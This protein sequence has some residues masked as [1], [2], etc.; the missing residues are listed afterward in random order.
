M[1]HQA[2]FFVISCITLSLVF[3][4]CDVEESFLI[5]ENYSNVTIVS[6]FISHAEDSSWGSDQLPLN[7]LR[8]R[9]KVTIAVEPGTYGVK[10]VSEY[11]QEFVYETTI[12]SGMTTTVAIR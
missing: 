1:R 11:G 9:S 6:I 10:I 2:L 5:V 3:C 8:P 4:G 7:V 12:V